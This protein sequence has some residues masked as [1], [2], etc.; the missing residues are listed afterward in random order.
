MKRI[1]GDGEIAWLEKTYPVTIVVNFAVPRDP[2][3]A[4]VG[5]VFAPQGQ[6]PTCWSRH[7]GQM[8]N[9]V[10]IW[11]AVELALDVLQHHLPGQNAVI[12]TCFSSG[13]IHN[14]RRGSRLYVH[15]DR[16][17]VMLRTQGKL[18]GSVVHFRHKAKD[19]A[20]YETALWSAKQGL[21]QPIWR[22]GFFRDLGSVERAVEAT[23]QSPI[24]H[25]LLSALAA[26]FPAG[27]VHV[28]DRRQYAARSGPYGLLVPQYHVRPYRRSYHLDFAVFSSTGKMICIETDGAQYHTKPE[29]RARDA[30]R[31]RELRSLGWQI[32]RFTGSEV[33]HDAAGC[34][35]RVLGAITSA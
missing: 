13:G 27:C 2:P 11:F 14:L 3:D 32:L 29:D 30:E 9:G 10:A 4:A 31:D 5:C 21:S 19:L 18:G 26:F 7:V 24:E 17:D 23:M 1:L 33:F 22:V 34:A 8:T 35:R 25:G 6:V 12:F 28:V 16:D 20:R 15:E